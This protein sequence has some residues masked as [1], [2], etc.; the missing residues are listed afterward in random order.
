ML[1]ELFIDSKMAKLIEWLMINDQVEWTQSEL[2]RELDIYAKKMRKFIK[3]LLKHDL[4]H[5]TRRIA[6]SRMYRVNTKSEMFPFLKN[7]VL[8]IR[9]HVGEW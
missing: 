7:F 9:L 8:E 4:I 3:V 6:N 2:C 1:E 5:E